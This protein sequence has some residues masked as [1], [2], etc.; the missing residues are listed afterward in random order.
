MNSTRCSTPSSSEFIVEQFDIGVYNEK[1]DF[2]NH[3]RIGAFEGINPSDSLAELAEK[4]DTHDQMAY[5]AASTFSRW[6]NDRDYRAVV[7]VLFSDSI[8]R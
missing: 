8:S 7:R 1:H 3:L 5:M 6:T 4:T 2:D